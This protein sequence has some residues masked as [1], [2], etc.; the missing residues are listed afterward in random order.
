MRTHALAWRHDTAHELPSFAETVSYI[1]GLRKPSVHQLLTRADAAGEL[2][3]QPRCGV[4][5]QEKMAELLRFLE[6]EARPDILSLTIDAYTRLCQFDKAA[7][8]LQENPGN[9]NGYPLVCHGYR[10]VRELNELV[11][12]PIEIRHGSPDARLLFEMSIAGGVTSFEGGGI[13]YNLP[14]SK[15]VPVGDSLRA[16]RYVDQRCGELAQHGIIVDRE[17]FGTLSAVL[18]PP[19]VGLAMTLLEALCAV[20][21]GVR[22]LSIAYCQGGHMAQDA[23][24]LRAIRELAR[25]YL[26]PEVG[27][28]PVLHQFMG[29]FPVA[30]HDA[31]ALILRGSL[32]A[33][34]GRATKIINK[35][36]EEA[37]GIPTPGANAQGI[38]TTRVANSLI[39][40]FV[41]LDDEEV[42]EEEHWIIRE[43]EEIVAPILDKA[44]LYRAIE[45]GFAEGLLDIPFSASRYAQSGVLPMRDRSGAIRYHSAGKLSLGEATRQRNARLLRDV[46]DSPAFSLFKKL[47][48]DIMYFAD[49]SRKD[50]IDLP[51]PSVATHD[52]ETG[53]E[54]ADS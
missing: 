2:L 49:V 8:V 11:R 44:D 13:C 18:I 42:A 12:A 1:K 5:A 19:S 17:L 47:T 25:R 35:T 45:D 37:L 31:E 15:S 29:A 53:H 4:G 32:A 34:M 51:T 40:D 36:H 38:W 22:C 20:K 3:I 52:E 30:R 43:V 10:K 39:S 23:A 16:W 7:R 54:G 21:E 24:A 48:R 33:R 26:P 27:V 6:Q 46:S 14:Y 41:R 28:F 50:V 9:L